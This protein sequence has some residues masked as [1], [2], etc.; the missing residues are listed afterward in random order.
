MIS[1]LTGGSWNG[2]YVKSGFSE[3]FNGSLFAEGWLLAEAPA[4]IIDIE[5]GSSTDEIVN[6]MLGFVERDDL[7]WRH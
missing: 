1:S 6:C 4:V 7:C 5:P 2:R 3:G